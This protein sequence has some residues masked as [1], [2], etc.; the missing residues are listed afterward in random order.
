[1]LAASSGHEKSSAQTA[2]SI[3]TGRVRQTGLTR[4]DGERERRAAGLL[5]SS[6]LAMR[7]FRREARR[8]TLPGSGSGLP[9]LSG[10]P[11][12]SS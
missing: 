10:V 2:R 5:E 1:M 4:G 12:S 3:G 11:G 7:S 8:C 9:G 6:S